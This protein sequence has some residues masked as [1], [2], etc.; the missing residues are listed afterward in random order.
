MVPYNKFL[1]GTW[2]RERRFPVTL[3]QIVLHIDH[4]CQLTGNALHVGIGSDIDGGFGRDEMPVEL[5]TVADI[6]RVADA[7]RNIGYPEDA[8]INIM[9][10]NWRRCLE[11]ALPLA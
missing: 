8:V 10:G 5:D 1:S 9:G 6:A 2:T 4:I 3:D 7:L 11:H